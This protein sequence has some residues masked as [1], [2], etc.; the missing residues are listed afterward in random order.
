MAQKTFSRRS[1][2]AAPAAVLGTTALAQDA[3]Y[4]RFRCK[5]RQSD[6]ERIGAILRKFNYQGYVSLEFEGKESTDTALPKSLEL[7]RRT[8]H[9]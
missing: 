6:Y 8:L 5:K 2:L 9:F 4:T 1:F 3:A 7:L